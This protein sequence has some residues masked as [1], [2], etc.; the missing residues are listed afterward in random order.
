MHD[1]ETEAEAKV[2]AADGISYDKATGKT[3][4]IDQPRFR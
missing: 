2:E 1:A 3:V 4:A